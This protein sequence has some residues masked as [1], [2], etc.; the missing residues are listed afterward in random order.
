MI[1]KAVLA[2]G[3]NMGDRKYF[4]RE[5]VSLLTH[6]GEIDIEARSS[7]YQ[8]PPLD[9]QTEQA[10]YLNQV[11]VVRTGLS[12][13]ELLV[14]CQEVEHQLGRPSDHEA[15][16]P[17]VIDLDLITHGSTVCEGSSLTL[18]HPRYSGRKFVLVPLAEVMPS[19]GDPRTGETIWE[20][21]ASC[22]DTS[23]IQRWNELQEQPC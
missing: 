11:I 12:A 16:M 10:D 4:L 21:L 17:R 1:E 9:V 23:E 3:S 2:L 5:A 20:I 14:R 6:P 22:P 13:A 7:I 15:G 18:P 8:T 19:F